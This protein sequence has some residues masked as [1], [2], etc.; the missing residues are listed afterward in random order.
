MTISPIKPIYLL[1]ST[2]KLKLLAPSLM[3]IYLSACGGSD[4]DPDDPL[5]TPT[6]SQEPTPTVEPTPTPTAA[7]TV[8]PTLRQPQL[9]NLRQQQHLN[10]QQRQAQSLLLRLR[11][12][13]QIHQSYHVL[14]DTT[15][16][17]PVASKLS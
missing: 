2:P 7:P 1:A 8:A 11:L 5:A 3:A 13:R 15:L 9:Q 6:P 12:P 16:I 10:Q 17:K 14:M 4:V